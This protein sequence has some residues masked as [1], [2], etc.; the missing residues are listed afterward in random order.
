MKIL[1][2]QM[3]WRFTVFVCSKHRLMYIMTRYLMSERNGIMSL[4]EATEL[5]LYTPIIV[6]GALNNIGDTSY[7]CSVPQSTIYK[8]KDSK[9]RSRLSADTLQ[10]LDHLLVTEKFT[11]P[12]PIYMEDQA[13]MTTNYRSKLILLLMKLHFALK[14]APGV[15]SLAVNILDRFLTKRNVEEKEMKVAGLACLLIASKVLG[16]TNYDEQNEKLVQFQTGLYYTADD[17]IHTELVILTGLKYH[18]SVPTS[19][20]FLYI[21]LEATGDLVHKDITQDASFIQECTLPVYA[22]LDYIPSKIASGSIFIA[23][24][25]NGVTPWNKALAECTTY[26]KEAV[27]P[28]VKTILYNIIPRIECMLELEWIR[29]KFNRMNKSKISK[30]Q[31]LGLMIGKTVE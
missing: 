23:R 7:S 11:S 19:Y 1:H 9:H 2:N 30:M 16:G 3:R 25:V 14:L 27:V 21:Y 20:T 13:Y 10:L 6:G 4:V 12:L 26:N 24:M 31:E 17:V 15:S 29:V 28:I 22:L 5:I 8:D 18:V